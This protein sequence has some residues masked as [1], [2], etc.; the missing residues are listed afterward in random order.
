[1]VNWPHGLGPVA[2]Q[3]F[4]R[5]VRK[6]RNCLLHG[7]QEIKQKRGGLK[8][9]YPF[10]QKTSKWPNRLNIQSPL[11]RLL[12]QAFNMWALNTY[13][14]P[15]NWTVWEKSH[16]LFGDQKGSTVLS[17]NVERKTTGFSSY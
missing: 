4:R 15:R 13:P 2:R 5:A 16:I 6:R 11:N 7:G 3:Y 1:M 14:N 12:D 9:G 8:A 17:V 10:D